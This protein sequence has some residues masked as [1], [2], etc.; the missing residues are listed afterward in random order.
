MPLP[1]TVSLVVA[2]GV[3]AAGMV[4]YWINKLNR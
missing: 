3:F 1:V 2:G 4:V